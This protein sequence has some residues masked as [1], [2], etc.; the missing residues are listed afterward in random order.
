MI[1]KAFLALVL[2]LVLASCNNT[3]GPEDTYENYVVLVSFDGFRWDY[4]DL[5][6]TPGFDALEQEG[7]KAERLISSFPTKTFPNHYTIATGLYPGHHGLVNNTF[8]APDL[9][10][11]YRISDRSMVE[12]PDFYGGEPIW[13]TAEKQGVTAASFF[14][15]GSEAPV[16][17]MQPTYWKRYDGSI[18]FEARIDS[19]IDWLKLPLEKRP[20]LITLYFQQPDGIGHAFGPVHTE[21]GKVIVEMDRLLQ[22]LRKDICKL[23]YGDRVNLIV[24]SDHGM[25]STSGSRY[26]NIYD[27]IPRSWVITDFGY[28]P[29]YLLNVVDGYED[30]VVMKLDPVAGVS[31]WKKENM[32]AHMHY[33]SNV[34]IPDIVVAADSSWSVGVE[35]DTTGIYGGAHGYDTRNTDM[36]AIF[37][38]DGPDFRDGYVHPP[39]ENVHIYSLIAHLLGLEPAETDGDIEVVKGMLSKP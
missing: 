8:F 7:V 3:N 2:I 21:T 26:V 33:S 9:D 36:H 1:Q 39:F 31:A 5:Y 32:P 17:G 12:D 28:N 23:P 35:S 19:V 24:T 11:I 29:V 37:Y 27:H 25:G 34:R 14:W 10:K 16:G 20:R 22:K 15:V 18:P 38:A 4:T 30:S 6:D 13:N